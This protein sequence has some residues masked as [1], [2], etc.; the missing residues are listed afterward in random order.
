[1]RKPNYSMERKDRDRAKQ[2]KAAAK[3]GKRAEKDAES[4]RTSS[5]A[6]PDAADPRGDESTKTEG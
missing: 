2:A 3:L 4:R 6:A 1:M 5:S